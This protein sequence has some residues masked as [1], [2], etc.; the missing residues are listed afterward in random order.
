MRVRRRSG[1]GATRRREAT[2]D[3]EVDQALDAM[4]APELRAAIR[5]VLDQ[6][7]D[8][9]KDFII[10]ALMARGAKATSGW[11]P[12]RPSPR[13][14][15]EAK[16]FSDAARQIGQA[17]PDDVTEHL[18]RAT[19]AYLA[20]DHASARAVFEA[21]LPPIARVDIDLGQHELV[22]EVL[23]VGVRRAVRRER[24]CDD[25]SSRACGRD[26]SSARSGRGRRGAFESDQGHGGRLRR[27]VRISRR[28]FRCG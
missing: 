15:E 6:L 22:E 9:V 27:G 17:D 28:S 26:H 23:R 18:R 13:I 4:S 3:P 5:V 21:I 25:G 8:G 1:H 14:V 19:K 7:D 20:G 10:D 11:K 12:A 2:G 24:V 16:S